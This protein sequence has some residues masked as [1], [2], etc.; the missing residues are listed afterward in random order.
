MRLV[1][2][3][4][5]ASALPLAADAAPT[6]ADC[7][8]ID[9][10]QR[11]LA[12][13][14][15]VSGR[16]G[17]ASTTIGAPIKTLGGDTANQRD[18]DTTPL[19]APRV[20]DPPMASNQSAAGSMFG[21]AWSFD[22]ESERYLIK[23]YRPNFLNPVRYQ[24]RTNDRPF[25]PVFGALEQG[26][27][28][29][30]NLET[31]FQIS[32]K[33]RL[34]ASKGRRLGFWFAYT[35]RSFWQVY[36]NDLSSPF[37]DSNYLPELMLA[38]Q[39]RLSFGGF[40]WSLLSIGYT[41][42]SN[43]RADPVSRSW[44]RLIAQIGIEKDDFALLIRPWIRIDDEGSDSENPDIT[45]YFGYGDITAIYKWQGHSFTLMAR[46][47]PAEAKGAVRAT[48]MTPKILGPLR[49]YLI[50]FSGYGDTLIDYNF[51]QNAVSVGLALN[52][53]LDQ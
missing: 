6:I 15:R 53:L 30:D 49:G 45:D 52:D 41:H 33:T 11:R 37:R 13:Y 42:E 24:S 21:R 1:A 9:D 28:D 18:P 38:W 12:C 3:T 4:V 23:L 20:G 7:A 39:P 31:V 32:F 14:D 35:Q 10:G 47:N 22:P 44:D 17:S 48:W 27:G 40:D 46:G 51:K 34:W 26:D 29:Q 2:L 16:A 36:N 8:R 43:G 50:G 19:S 25:S 5:I